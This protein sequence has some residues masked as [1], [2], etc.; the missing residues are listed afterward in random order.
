MAI[1]TVKD[2]DVK[3]KKVIVRCDFNVPLDENQRVTDEKRIVESLPTITYLVEHGAKVIL[4]SH[5]GRPKGKPVPSM[6][7]APVAKSLSVLLGNTVKLAPDCIGP[8]VANLASGLSEGDVLLLEN[9]RFYAEEEAN[10]QEFAK[11]LA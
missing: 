10:D 4:M 11:K 6:S 8:D 1:K 7:L 5:L 3:G 9:L 2:I